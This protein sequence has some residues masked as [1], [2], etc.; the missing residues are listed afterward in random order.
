LRK[1]ELVEY[2]FLDA[3]LIIERL[4]GDTFFRSVGLLIQVALPCIL[5][6]NGMTILKLRGGTNAEMAPQID[7]ITEVCCLGFFYHSFM[8]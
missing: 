7:Y 6:S 2:N 8:F 5:F 1:N 3:S 4:I